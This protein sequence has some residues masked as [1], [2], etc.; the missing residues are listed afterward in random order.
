MSNTGQPTKILGLKRTSFWR[1]ERTV[2]L[3]SFSWLFLHAQFPALPVPGPIA[4]VWSD[5][6]EC[7]ALNTDEVL[8]LTDHSLRGGLWLRG[9][10]AHSSSLTF[11]PCSFLLFPCPCKGP[12]VTGVRE[13]SV[14]SQTDAVGVGSR[15]LGPLGE[16]CPWYTYSRE[17]ADAHSRAVG[18]EPA[19]LKSFQCNH[20]QTPAHHRSGTRPGEQRPCHHLPFWPS[21]H[22]PK[23]FTKEA[24]AQFCHMLA[25]EEDISFFKSFCFQ[26]LWNANEM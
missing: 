9:A 23:G 3:I 13:G 11:W 25:T 15:G 4:E 24:G 14:S 8:V 5:V 2:H 6:D 20:Q 26:L 12:F 7:G 22:P 21:N 17:A 10:P 18:A 16:V 1:T 19:R